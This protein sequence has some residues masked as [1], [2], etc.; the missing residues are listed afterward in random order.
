MND[1]QFTNDPSVAHRPFD[2]LPNELMAMILTWVSKGLS[3]IAERHKF[4]LIPGTVSRR[5]KAVVDAT[6]AL[7][8]TVMVDRHQPP[9]WLECYLRKSGNMP[10]NVYFPDPDDPDDGDYIPYPPIPTILTLHAKRWETLIVRSGADRELDDF[11]QTVA[12][13][14]TSLLHFSAAT[15]HEWSNVSDHP[16][17]NVGLLSSTLRSLHLNRVSPRWMPTQFVF[18]DLVE[19]LINASD[20]KEGCADPK[21]LL[22]T[23][24]ACPRLKRLGIFCYPL[25]EQDITS[26]LTGRACY[27]TAELRDL[28]ELVLFALTIAEFLFLTSQISCP[29]ICTLGVGIL[30]SDDLS[31]L[32]GVEHD[33]L[34]PVYPHL[35][36]L[37]I[38]SS[39]AD[40]D[41]MGL[42][43][44][45][46]KSVPTLG[47]LGIGSY[48]DD[49]ESIV[50]DSYIQCLL[51]LRQLGPSVR[52][53]KTHRL[54]PH[55]LRIILR[56][57]CPNIE[58]IQIHAEDIDHMKRL[59]G[60][61]PFV[62]SFLGL[63]EITSWGEMYDGEECLTDIGD[64]RRCKDADAVLYKYVG[65]YC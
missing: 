48:I 5:W 19:L 20:S 33:M 10:L 30:P 17:T 58:E 45:K 60:P 63:P 53:L 49:E 23:L 54:G 28:D 13:L 25:S 22:A 39:H 55:A 64:L 38:L 3:K 34:C 57:F 36:R 2:N 18:P 62:D 9:N 27:C 24:C 1:Q 59:G 31:R 42:A 4:P 32:Q 52:T 65:L 12:P 51:Q 44:H 40:P 26:G 7:W 6:P 8:T 41:D 15:S 14:A 11:L 43:L 16:V 61:L 46:I 29:N 21:V 37:D 35:R 56:E 47:V 50:G